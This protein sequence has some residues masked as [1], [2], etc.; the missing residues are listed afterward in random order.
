MPTAPVWTCIGAHIWAN[1]RPLAA[2]YVRGGARI[3]I[4]A[5]SAAVTAA[6]PRPQRGQHLRR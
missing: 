2:S 5:A 6:A 4:A 1:E 3:G